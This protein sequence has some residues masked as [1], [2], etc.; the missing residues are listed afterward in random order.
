MA[1]RPQILD[2]ED[3]T[4][5]DAAVAHIRHHAIIVQLP[6]VFALFAMPNRDGVAMIDAAKD[7]KPGKNYGTT[8]GDI[9]R[10]FGMSSNTS[11]LAKA[12]RQ[13]GPDH[14]SRKQ[15]LGR[16]SGSFLRIKVGPASLETPT[17]RGGSHQSLL[18]D[19]LHGQF[20][21]ALEHRLIGLADPSLYGGHAFAAPIC[22]SC[23]I[24]GDPDGSIT[25]FDRAHEF[26]VRRA[27]PLIIRS[28]VTN[29]ELGSFPVFELSDRAVIVHRNGPRVQELKAELE[30]M[31][32][33]NA[34]EEL[35]PISRLAA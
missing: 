33:E 35:P 29:S 8:A 14:S 3:T 6:T 10:F 24:S 19:G 32:T 13:A 2:I 21:D 15:L 34:A 18:L 30:A 5:V 26:A 22:S 9:E 12:V 11:A 28:R 27:I 1:Y 31:L 4:A 25:S 20:F 17:V 23:N 16:I 7:R